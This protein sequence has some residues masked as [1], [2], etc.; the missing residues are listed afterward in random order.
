VN[1]TIPEPVL[2]LAPARS[3]SSVFTAMLGAHPQLFG[4]PELAL[5]GFPT[6]GE[7]IDRK[8]AAMRA[9]GYRAVTAPGATQAVAEIVFGGQGDQEVA[10]A[11]TWL[12][13]RRGE[14]PIQVLD[15]LR[16]AVAP[17][18]IVEQSPETVMSAQGLHAVRESYPNA[19]V[20]HLVRHPVSSVNSM[21]NFWKDWPSFAQDEDKWQRALMLWIQQHHRIAEFIS[22]SDRGFTVRSEDA[23]GDDAVL[24]RLCEFLGID[25]G[26]SAVTAMRTGAS[27]FAGDIHPDVRG[28]MDPAC[29][30]D[31]RPRPVPPVV[32]VSFPREWNIDPFTQ[33]QA[34]ALAR[35]LGYECETA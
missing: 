2:V 15:A 30:V 23:L 5:L 27:P 31:S 24:V 10:A 18:A 28:A 20:I 7:A 6:V 4:L 12:D 16:S 11:L 13:E 25:A 21:I 1:P 34:M 35:S 29:A 26:P 33:M 14:S 3:Y 9:K 22:A 32:P 19:W 17:R 8:I